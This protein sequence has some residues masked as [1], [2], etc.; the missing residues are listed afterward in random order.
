LCLERIY[1]NVTTVW[2]LQA[3]R[4]ELK[5]ERNSFEKM[6]QVSSTLV[7]VSSTT[8]SAC[9]DLFCYAFIDTE[10]F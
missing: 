7:S 6:I 4:M 2:F 5:N 9:W 10:R 3:I 1:L 8:Y